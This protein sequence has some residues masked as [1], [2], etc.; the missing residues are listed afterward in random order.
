[1]TARIIR[2]CL[3]AGLLNVA[4]LAT[5]VI[6]Q[7]APVAKLLVTVVD[8]TGAVLPNAT[9]TIV[10]TEAATKVA[11]LVPVKA[12]A[13]GQATLDSLV[14]GRYTV[15]AEFPGFLPAE[16]KDQRLRAGDN[17]HVLILP[18]KGMTEGV[19][20]GRDARD[21]ATDRT[22]TFGSVLTR[23]QIQALS[24]DPD[25]MR[26]QLQ[27]MGGP[28]AVIKVDSFEGQQLPPK[29]Q[30][31]SIRISRDQFAAENHSAFSSIDIITQPG[32]GPLR[33]SVRGNFYDSSM[34]GKNPLVNARGPGQNRGGGA[35]LGGTVIKNKADFS[36]SFNGA[37]NWTSPQ[38]YASTIGGDTRAEYLRIKQ[39]SVNTGVNGLLNYALTKDQTIRIGV[40]YGQNN[41]ENLGVGQHDNVERAY[42][43]EST[44][45]GLR[46][47]ETGPV[48]RRMVTN[49]R[50]M[51]NVNRTETESVFDGVTIVVPDAF[52]RG[53]AQRSGGS[54]ARSFAFQQDLDY[55]RGLHSWRAGVMFDGGYSSTTTSTNYL[56][57]YTFESVD[58]FNEGR[59]RTYTRR[60]GDPTVA[61]WN[62][63]SALY[64]Q[65]DY[66][67]RKNLSLSLGLRY[68]TQF[69]VDDIVNF[70]PRAGFT[71]S[72][73]KSGRMSV[74][75]S[76]GLFS[77]WFPMGTYAQVLQTDGTRQ[78]DIN[79]LNPTF[80]DPG[81]LPPSTPVNRYLH[82]DHRNMPQTNRTSAGIS[83]S[84]KRLSLGAIYAYN[85]SSNQLVGDNLNAPVNGVRPDAAYANVIRAVG[86]AE[87]R[88]H[89]V[90]G[91]LNVSLAPGP[92]T[93]GPSSG[94]AASQPFFS[95][96]RSL[97]VS[98]YFGGNIA[99]NN[100]DGPFA[101]PASGSLAGE[102]GPS[103]F[104]GPWNISINVNS[105]MIKNLG[106]NWSINASAGPYYTIRTGIDDNRDAILN[107]RPAG[108]GR[109]TERGAASLN[110]YMSLNYSLGFGKQ[111]APGGGLAGVP[112]IIERGGAVAVSMGPGGPAS[113][114]RYRVNFSVF[115][116]NPTNHANYGSYSGVMTSEFFKQPTSAFGVRRITFNMGLSF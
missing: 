30:I 33:T 84:I 46:F 39:P 32:I 17:K 108:V 4:A 60:I 28:D 22:V 9:V 19:V 57:T 44:S 41:R 72:P 113:I 111:A 66:K 50:F 110:S 55:V 36:L 45:W 104:G 116:E 82:E 81:P 31:K 10:G 79:I 38:L 26:R 89:S 63:Q 95:L 87:S 18:L 67:P 2:V 77:D 100:S 59:P 6:A 90:S 61:Y 80:P 27:E 14:P 54:E 35:T 25:E 43:Q 53:G 99:R 40:N 83:G 12:D 112:M 24:D 5:T 109:N 102:W 73:L 42:S 76:W 88:T 105:G 64:V 98:T 51:L 86:L 97:S 114:P 68:E 103:A 75:A 74:R 48:G 7:T 1:M 78:R 71:W 47:Q 20:V 85:K 69:R 56:G 58:A 52:T 106:V 94:P 16:L 49:T 62:V 23:E 92:G 93:G 11:T 37:N 34:D 101:V 65:D 21:V 13:K 29:A 8:Q 70:S 15:K 96:R 115:I 3:V 91:N 107:D